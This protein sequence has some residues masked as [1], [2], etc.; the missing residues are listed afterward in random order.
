MRKAIHKRRILAGVLAL[1]AL[2]A[3]L[4]SAF[5]VAAE[6]DH[7][8]TGEDC[9]VC[10]LIHLCE[11]LLRSFAAVILMAAVLASVLLF[12]A[13]ARFACGFRRL[14]PVSGR[15]RMNN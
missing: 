1:A 4:L 7:D 12:F 14:T 5:Y 11:N 3:L 2:L 9:A 10:A 8:C 13:A 6:A 15:V